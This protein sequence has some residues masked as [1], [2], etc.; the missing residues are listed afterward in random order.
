MRHLPI[1]SLD[2]LVR[3]NKVANQQEDRHD[4]MLCDRHNVGAS[5]FEDLDVFLNGGIEIDMVAAY[6]S[7]DTDFE[8][9]GLLNQITSKIPGVEWRSDDDL[10][11]ANR[12]VR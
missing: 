11:L 9:L 7:R 3:G 4:D 10:S 12:H 2:H 6:T 8:V 1:A 5:D